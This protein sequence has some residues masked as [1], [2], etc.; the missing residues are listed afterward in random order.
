MSASLIPPTFG[1]AA[2]YF[3][4]QHWTRSRSVGLR[5]WRVPIKMW[6][7][8]FP[9]VGLTYSAGVS[10]ARYWSLTPDRPGGGQHHRSA[11]GGVYL[12]YRTSIARVADANRYLAQVQDF[13]MSAIEN[14]C[15]GSRRE[16]S[17]H[18]WPHQALQFRDRASEASGRNGGTQQKA[19]AAAALLHDMG[20]LAIPEHILNKPGN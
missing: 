16:R 14:P 13:D 8:N 5:T 9:S 7:K 15:D 1:F 20:K 10:V 4:H 18:S 2:I 3:L 11:V 12:T 17:D 19:I 6:V